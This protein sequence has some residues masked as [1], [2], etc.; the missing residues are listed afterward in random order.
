[1]T[2]MD[3][4]LKT[5]AYENLQQKILEVKVSL[6]ILSG[7]ARHF[8]EKVSR[9]SVERTKGI[10]VTAKKLLIWSSVIIALLLACFANEAQNLCWMSAFAIPLIAI[11][12][13]IFAGYKNENGKWQLI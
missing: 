13:T 12:L 7:I 2:N 5:E 3:K 4:H 8:F 9:S 11:F 1:M 6:V 10:K